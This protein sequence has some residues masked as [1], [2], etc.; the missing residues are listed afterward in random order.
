MA[1]LYLLLVLL[2]FYTPV[3][4]LGPSLLQKDFEITISGLHL[5][6]PFTGSLRLLA[7]SLLA[8]WLLWTITLWIERRAEFDIFY[9]LDRRLSALHLRERWIYA[10]RPAFSIQLAVR[11]AE[12]GMAISLGKVVGALLLGVLLAVTV[13]QLI[14]AVL[15]G[16][17]ESLL[18]RF[19]GAGWVETLVGWLSGP[20]MEWLA[21]SVMNWL[22]DAL[23]DLLEFRLHASLLAISILTLM[24]NQAY[25][26]ER[27]ERYRWDIERMQKERKQKQA[28][29]SAASLVA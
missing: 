8:W 11:L 2:V 15:P 3:V 13:P 12:I 4:G 23:D 1:W 10:T 16:L 28:F 9:W 27:V 21:G 5:P 25:Q 20:L 18:A 29:L 7:Y 22:R 6:I 17:I 14:H 24:A 26:Q 19:P